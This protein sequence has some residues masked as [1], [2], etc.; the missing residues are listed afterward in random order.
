MLDILQ[1]Y[2]RVLCNGMKMR[3]RM[4]MIAHPGPGIGFYKRFM[5]Q[6]IILPTTVIPPTMEKW[7]MR[8]VRS[9]TPNW[10]G[11][12]DWT[13]DY[14]TWYAVQVTKGLMKRPHGYQPKT[15]PTHQNSTSYSTSGTPINW[16][17]RTV[18]KEP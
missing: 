12:V 2:F 3:F 11:A 6:I 8:L 7:N 4:V 9:W 10:T 5:W 1:Y 15:S 13:I 14:T 16:V 18:K 17:P